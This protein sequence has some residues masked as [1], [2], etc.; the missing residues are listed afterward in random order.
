MATRS[1]WAKVPRKGAC[2]AHGTSES[3]LRN[4]ETAIPL[5][6]RAVLDRPFDSERRAKLADTYAKAQRADDAISEMGKALDLDPEE[7]VYH[8][9]LIGYALDARRYDNALQGMDRYVEAMKAGSPEHRDALNWVAG[10]QQRIPLDAR[11][12]ATS[13]T[14]IQ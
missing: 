5:L 2:T 11:R 14:A 7:P 3:E 1:A 8:Q 13:S 12:S 10:Q 4:Y 9:L 6:E